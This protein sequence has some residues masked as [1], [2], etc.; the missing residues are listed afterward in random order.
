[1]VEKLRVNKYEIP[2]AINTWG[3]T[4]SVKHRRESKYEKIDTGN[5]YGKTSRIKKNW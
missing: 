5:N 3:N 4:I 1:M 2:D